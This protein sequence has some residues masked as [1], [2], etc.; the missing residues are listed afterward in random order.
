MFTPKLELE[1]IQDTNTFYR[2]LT[3]FKSI[4]KCLDAILL[5]IKMHLDDK[6]PLCNGNPEVYEELSRYL[7]I[8][9]SGLEEQKLLDT[10]LEF[11]QIQIKHAGTDQQRKATATTNLA[12]YKNALTQF[13]NF[14]VRVDNTR[15][16]S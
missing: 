7:T 3:H 10:I 13:E 11:C 15:N 6:I 12:Y 8:I 5:S 9:V 14:K 2:A 1:E 16:V 4:I